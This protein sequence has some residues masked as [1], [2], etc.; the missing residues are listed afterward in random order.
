MSST[1]D[2]LQKE[3]KLLGH[4]DQEGHRR[5]TINEVF[6]VQYSPVGL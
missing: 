4:C 5:K 1:N 2:V 3:K 6:E